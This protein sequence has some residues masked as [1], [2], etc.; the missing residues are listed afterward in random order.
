MA[1]QSYATAGRRIV[2]RHDRTKSVTAVVA[3]TAKGGPNILRAIIDRVLI[4]RMLNERSGSR[5]WIR[6]DA[7]AFVIDATRDPATNCRNPIFTVIVADVGDT[8]T[9]CE[10]HRPNA[11]SFRICQQDRI[12]C[13]LVTDAGGRVFEFPLRLRR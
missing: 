8:V 1:V 7:H 13:R 9:A 11:T 3:A 4:K 2:N 10:L 6:T 12:G 5:R